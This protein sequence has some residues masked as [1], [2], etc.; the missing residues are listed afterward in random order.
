MICPYILSP[1]CADGEPLAPVEV[2]FYMSENDLT[3]LTVFWGYAPVPADAPL[4]GYT[5]K[6]WSS[7]INSPQEIQT[8][9]NETMI[10][11]TSL[12]PGTNYTIVVGGRN[13]FGLGEYS[14]PM[15][16][17]TM[18]GAVPPPPTEVEAEVKSS[19]GYQVDVTIS[20][21]VI[22]LFYGHR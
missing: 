3:S 6:Y 14:E 11:L 20:W 7:D 1:V 10:K 22:F 12:A 21:K 8:S 5:I 18:K 19:S 13:S 16:V 2:P 15:I 9:D 17:T 4:F